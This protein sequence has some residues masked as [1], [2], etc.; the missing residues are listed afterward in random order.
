V[1]HTTTVSESFEAGHQLDDPVACRWAHGHRWTVSVT[2]DGTLDPKKVYV[3]DHGALLAAL[4]VVVDELRDR[5]LDDMLP[6]VR[7][8]PEG[9]A[10]YFHERLA[11]VQPR[12]VAVS[13]G[14][15]E[16]VQVRVEWDVR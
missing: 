6:G 16:G 13:V 2:V 3:V 4:R 15:G 5:N 8:T 1:R 12:I 14:M 7:S 10:I 9:L 11:L